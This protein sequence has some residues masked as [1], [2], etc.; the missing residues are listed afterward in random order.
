MGTRELAAGDLGDM[1]AVPRAYDVRPELDRTLQDIEAGEGTEAVQALIDALDANLPAAGEGRENAVDQCR[2]HVLHELMLED[3]LSARAWAR[4]HGYPGDGV[5]FDYV[6]FRDA[7]PDTSTI[8]RVIFERTTTSGAARSVRYR[9]ELMARRI[10]AAAA[11]KPRAAVLSVGCGHLRE[12]GL[13]RAVAEDAI[14][15]FVA[16][17]HDP[18]NVAEVGRA[19]GTRGIEATAAGVSELLKFG[20]PGGFDLVYAAGLCDCLPD[21][22]AQ[23]LTARLFDAVLPG[24]TLLLANFAPRHSGHG[25]MTAFLDWTL[26]CRGEAAVRALASSIPVQSATSHV[27]A[28]PLRNVLYLEI[29]RSRE[30]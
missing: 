29:R 3:P 16:L 8:G 23:S 7:P 4:P 24:G 12:A 5:L 26:Q 13:S 22:T 18:A 10:D 17:D 28:D 11:R 19:Y 30:S 2:E 21:A 1:V 20:A 6:Y 27:F 25:Y 14:G 9:R 15:R